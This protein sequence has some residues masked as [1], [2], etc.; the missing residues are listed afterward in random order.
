MAKRKKRREIGAGSPVFLE[1]EE[2]EEEEVDELEGA[3][4][5]QGDATRVSSDSSVATRAELPSFVTIGADPANATRAS[6]G[7]PSVQVEVSRAALE[8]RAATALPAAPL[9]PP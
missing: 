8:T 9:A 2:E 6:S 1:S 3:E 5:V 4:D 7:P